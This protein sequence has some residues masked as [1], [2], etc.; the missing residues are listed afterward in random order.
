[1]RHGIVSG[2]MLQLMAAGRCQGS[3]E[4]ASGASRLRTDDEFM[5]W[6]D[7]YLRTVI[8]EHWDRNCSIRRFFQR[9]A[10]VHSER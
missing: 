3:R 7:D 10:Q 1:M 2:L 5:S 8:R 4:Y 9:F 6:E